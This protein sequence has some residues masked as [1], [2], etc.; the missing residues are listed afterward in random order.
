MSELD[1]ELREVI[2]TNKARDAEREAWD[3]DFRR[4]MRR[5]LQLTTIGL[6]LWIVGLSLWIWTLVR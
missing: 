3:L 6:V 5:N 1:D 4:R 2:E